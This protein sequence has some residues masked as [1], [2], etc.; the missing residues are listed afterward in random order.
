M[1][2]FMDTQVSS[3][4]NQDFYLDQGYFFSKQ[5]RNAQMHDQVS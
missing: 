3:V 2:N 4:A 5:Q 1:V